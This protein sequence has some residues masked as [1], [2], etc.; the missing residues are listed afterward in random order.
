MFF[1][2]W[3]FTAGLNLVSCQQSRIL[4]WLAVACCLV[5]LN[6][7]GCR[8]ISDWPHA[9]L[10]LNSPCH[11]HVVC[12]TFGLMWWPFVVCSHGRL[13]RFPFMEN[14]NKMWKHPIRKDVAQMHRD[15]LRH[16]R[17]CYFLESLKTNKTQFEM[18][19]SHSWNETPGSF[20]T[21]CCLCC[22]DPTSV[23]ILMFV[24]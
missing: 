12:W 23:F 2:P 3:C 7:F 21:V 14:I 6:Y 24:R 11:H 9:V 22:S 13:G 20:H 8:R 16:L 4:P 19:I 15:G 1:S 17:L 10:P 18:K 5:H